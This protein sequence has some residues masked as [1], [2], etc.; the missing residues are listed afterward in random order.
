MSLQPSSSLYCKPFS[1]LYFSCY[2]IS[3]H[4]QYYSNTSCVH[5]FFFILRPSPLHS[6]VMYL[7]CFPSQS[8]HTP[9][10]MPLKCLHNFGTPTSTNLITFS[11]N[12]LMIF[13]SFSKHIF[14]LST[15]V[16]LTT[17]FILILSISATPLHFEPPHDCLHISINTNSISDSFSHS[18]SP[19][20]FR[21]S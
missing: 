8:Y 10:H 20:S 14:L 4:S 5:L 12:H 6:T 9:H 17:L 16:F 1:L 21:L 19:S 7:H 3:C 2:H 15:H 13:T 11:S 18:V